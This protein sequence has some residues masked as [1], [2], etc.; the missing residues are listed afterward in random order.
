MAGSVSH[1][2]RIAAMV[3]CAPH[4]SKD[5]LQV[6]R[7][8]LSTQADEPLHGKAEGASAPPATL[9]PSFHQIGAELEG[10]VVLDGDDASDT[11]CLDGVI[12]HRDRHVGQ[13]D[14]ARLGLLILKGDIHHP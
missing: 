13:E 1:A 4:G 6:I 2:D 3:D 7:I 8:P 11:G 5:L 14:D 12:G 10:A 9:G